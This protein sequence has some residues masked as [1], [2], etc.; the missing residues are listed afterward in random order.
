MNEQAALHLHQ[1]HGNRASPRVG[2]LHLA[3]GGVERGAQQVVAYLADP[4][5]DGVQ[6]IERD[7]AHVAGLVVHAENEV[8]ASPV[9][10]RRQLVRDILAAWSRYARS[11]QGDPL[12]LEDGILAKPDPSRQV[13]VAGHV[14]PIPIDVGTIRPSIYGRAPAWT[15]HRRRWQRGQKCVPRWAMTVRRTR[16]PQVGHGAPA[17]P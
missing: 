5:L 16:A 8:A 11:R 6:S 1:Q 13:A 2:Q 7:P 3:D 12:R 17:R 9:R 4:R 15:G 14:P 10:E